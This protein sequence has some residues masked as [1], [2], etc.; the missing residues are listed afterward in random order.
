LSAKDKKSDV[1][2]LVSNQL[3]YRIFEK[4]NMNFL[5]GVKL[6]I[7]TKCFQT[8]L[9]ICVNANLCVCLKEHMTVHCVFCALFMVCLGSAVSC[10]RQTATDKAFQRVQ[11][12]WS[13]GSS[14]C[15]NARTQM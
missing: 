3:S 12:S 5:L 2:S 10:N 6:F 8:H 14:L 4:S 1:L 7:R 11:N 13:I 15:L 9:R